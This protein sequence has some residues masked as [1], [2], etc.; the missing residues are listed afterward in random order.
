MGFFRRTQKH[1][2]NSPPAVGSFVARPRQTTELYQDM[3]ANP[4][5]TV[6]LPQGGGG[7]RYFPLGLTGTANGQI[8]TQTVQGSNG[9]SS[10]KQFLV[11]GKVST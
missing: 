8:S 5:R 10:T 4:Y 11:L 7:D 1:S 2:R 6:E 3:Y 9:Q